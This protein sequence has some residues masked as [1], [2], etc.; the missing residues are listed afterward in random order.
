M[1]TIEGQVMQY[2]LLW[3]IAGVLGFYATIVGLCAHFF[4]VNLNIPQIISSMFSSIK[5]VIRWIVY[6]ATR[7]IS[8]SEQ[9]ETA[10]L[11]IFR[12]RRGCALTLRE[13]RRLLED[14]YRDI[15]DIGETQ[16]RDYIKKFDYIEEVGGNGESA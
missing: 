12:E 5:S 14:K 15:S 11:R 8:F 16:L 10:V 6:R 1:I 7:R 4:E 3:F 9:L 2:G 13:L